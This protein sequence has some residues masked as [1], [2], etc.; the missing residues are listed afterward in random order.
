MQLEN[1]IPLFLKNYGIL[2]GIINYFDFW[3]SK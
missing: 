3:V 1:L 2:K